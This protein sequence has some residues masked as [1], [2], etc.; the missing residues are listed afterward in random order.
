MKICLIDYEEFQVLNR[1]SGRDIR[2]N[3]NEFNKKYKKSYQ[4]SIPYST[5]KRLEQKKL[6]DTVIDRIEGRKVTYYLLTE[7]G[8]EWYHKAREIEHHIFQN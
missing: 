8:I 6:T 5:L 2:Q 1:F 3:L 7:K 4:S